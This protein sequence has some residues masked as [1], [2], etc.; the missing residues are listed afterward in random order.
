[1]S[2]GPWEIGT[3]DDQNRVVKRV[4]VDRDPET[5]EVLGGTV[6]TWSYY[7]TGETE[8]IV[9]STRN[10]ENVETHRFTRHHF[11]DG[12][13]PVVSEQIQEEIPAEVTP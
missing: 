5:G 9:T 2:G 13:Q 4:E 1:M 11:R 6:T 7:K 3:K 10:A 8:D 12:R